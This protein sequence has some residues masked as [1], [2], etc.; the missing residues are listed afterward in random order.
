MGRRIGKYEITHLLGV[1]G[2][3][4]VL[5]GHDASIERDVA[6]KV[7]PAELSANQQALNRFLAEAKSAGKLNHPNAVTIYEIAQDG[8]H[9]FLVME[10]VSG[11]STEGRRHRKS[12][13]RLAGT[14]LINSGVGRFSTHNAASF[15]SNSAHVGRPAQRQSH[16]R[17]QRRSRRCD[18][19]LNSLGYLVAGALRLHR[20][21]ALN[22]C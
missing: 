6:I 17:D 10:V 1:G 4:V 2:M 13:A 15:A 16:R 9:H 12:E 19:C 20:R 14:S 7:L 5:K 11:G 8:D 21:M 22:F 3:G 18:I